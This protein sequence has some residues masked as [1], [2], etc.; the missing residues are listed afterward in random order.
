MGKI[1]CAGN[2]ERKL[3]FEIFNKSMKVKSDIFRVN[4]FIWRANY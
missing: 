1:I 3:Y 4:N 2:E